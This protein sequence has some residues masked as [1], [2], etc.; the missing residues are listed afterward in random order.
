MEKYNWKSIIA[1]LIVLLAGIILI[2]CDIYV[3]KTSMNLWVSIGCSLIASAMVILLNDIFVNKIKQN[4]LDDWNI[5]KIY[6]TRAEKNADSDPNL[7]KVK[8][9][10]DGV[11]FGLSSFRSK[12]TKKVES[13]LKRGVNFRILTMDPDGDFIS[14]REKEEG[15]V[16]GNITKSINDLVQWANRLNKKGYKGRIIIKGYNCMTLDFYWRVDDTIYIGPYWYGYKSSDTITYCF[17][18]G[19][20][21]FNLYSEYFD[22]LWENADLTHPL[23]DEKNIRK[24]KH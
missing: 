18:E 17:L 24:R 4:P 12:Y 16:E 11:A 13:C 23:T 21:G 19:G 9:C 14:S 2:I 1:G 6:K 15:E 20:K 10:V 7:D 5:K 22:S 8:Y 3:I